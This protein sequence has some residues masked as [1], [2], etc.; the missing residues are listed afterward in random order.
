MEYLFNY[1]DNFARK[2]SVKSILQ[3]GNT[4]ERRSP[5]ISVIMP[6]FRNPEMFKKALDSVV[7]QDCSFEYEVIVV[8]NEPYDGSKN[9]A[10]RYIESTNSN[11]IFY[12]RNTENIGMYENWNRGI[13][14]AKAQFITYCHNDDVFIPSALTRLNELQQ[15]YGERLIAS[16]FNLIDKD[17]A[18]IKKMNP[19]RRVGIFY[20]KEDFIYSKYDIFLNNAGFG[21]GC[22]FS[23][24]IMIELGGFNPEYYPSADY[25]LFAKYIFQS[26]G[27][28]N[29]IPTFNYRKSKNESYKAYTSFVERDKFFRECMLDKMEIPRWLGNLIIKANY[30]YGLYNF[31]YKWGGERRTGTANN[32]KK[33]SY[34]LMILINKLNS[35]RR[36]SLKRNETV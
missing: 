2:K 30:N 14:L 13:E 20:Q 36:F 28:F 15:R 32:Q 16:E 4:E 18:Y 33:A 11:F 27:V 19:K 23:K 24:R 17:G 25:A 22:L 34:I 8:D 10:L 9:E 5:V 1:I 21:V 7:S 35:M 29:R 12:Y 31:E 3:Y 26:G 6:I